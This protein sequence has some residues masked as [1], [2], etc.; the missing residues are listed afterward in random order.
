MSLREGLRAALPR[1]ELV[2]KLEAL[3]N[4]IL[5]CIERKRRCDDLL[6]QVQVLTDQSIYDEKY[7]GL[8]HGAS[9][10]REFAAEAALGAPPAVLDLGREEIVELIALA[11]RPN[12]PLSKYYLNLLA[13]NLSHSDI[14]NL[15]F[16]PDRKR[17]DEEIADEAILRDELW[18]EGGDV[19][20]RGH[21]RTQAENV[22][23]DPGAPPWARTWAQTFLR[24]TA[25]DSHVN[26]AL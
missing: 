22:M 9:S 24:G 14:V 10:P 13:K 20:V 18:H 7:F 17:S 3:A 2:A 5:N 8:L 21:L 16:W 23:A 6:H 11:S 15:I 4:Q 26:G 19:A 1:P 12:P 25:G